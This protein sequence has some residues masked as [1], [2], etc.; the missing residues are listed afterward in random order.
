MTYD[1]LKCERM[2]PMDGGLHIVTRAGRI[3]V[4]PKLKTRPEHAINGKSTSG[5]SARCWLTCTKLAMR[6]VTPDGS[7]PLRASAFLNTLHSIARRSDLLS[8]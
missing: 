1:D 3:I 4:S 5:W 8:R 7:A 6:T 2:L